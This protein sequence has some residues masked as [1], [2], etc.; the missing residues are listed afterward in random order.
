[1]K[2]LSI[3]TK[4]KT[5]AIAD[6]GLSGECK[7]LFSLIR[8]GPSHSAMPLVATIPTFPGLKCARNLA[9]QARARA[10]RAVVGQALLRVRFFLLPESHV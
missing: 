2:R 9:P 8:Q 4:I 6:R 1:M 10:F 3:L 7:A 5:P